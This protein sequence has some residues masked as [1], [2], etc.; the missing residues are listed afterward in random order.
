MRDIAEIKSF[1]NPP[2][3]LFV[4]ARHVLQVLGEKIIPNM[5]IQ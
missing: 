1:K 4:S 3:L 2:S 5:S